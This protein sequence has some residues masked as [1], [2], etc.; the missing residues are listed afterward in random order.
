MEKLEL[1]KDKMTKKLEDYIICDL[2]SIIYNE[3]EKLGY[4]VSGDVTPGEAMDQEN[5]CYEIVSH[6]ID[7]LIDDNYDEDEDQEEF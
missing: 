4:K 7:I 1:L 3:L 6:V 5:M 2:S